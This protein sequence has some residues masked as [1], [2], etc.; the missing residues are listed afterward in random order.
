MTYKE[1]QQRTTNGESISTSAGNNHDDRN[2]AG[3][4]D[5]G[6]ICA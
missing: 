2:A 4:S 6:G 5:Q 3:T 1:H